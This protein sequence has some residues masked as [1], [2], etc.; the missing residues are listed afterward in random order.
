MIESLKNKKLHFIGIGGCGMSGLAVYV[1]HLGANVAGSDKRTSPYIDQIRKNDIQV[2][3]GHD[4]KNISDCDIIIYSS[5]IKDDNCELSFARQKGIPTFR[6]GVFLADIIKDKK[7]IAVSGSHGKTST[8]ALLSW[9][10]DYNGYCPN[11]LVGGI[12]KNVNSNVMCTESDY[13]IVEA[14]ESDGSITFFEPDILIILNIDDDHIEHYGTK[15]KML[16]AYRKIAANT[17]E[18]V[19]VPDKN[20]ADLFKDSLNGAQLIDFSIE[21]LGFSEK[22]SLNNVPDGIEIE[23]VYKSNAPYKFY[24]PVFGQFFITNFLS[25]FAVSDRLGVSVEKFQKYLSEFKGVKRRA[26]DWGVVNGIRIIE[27]YAHHPTEILALLESLRNCHKDR[28]ICVF[29]PHRYTRSKNIASSLADSMGN[30]DL[31]VLTDIYSADEQ[32]IEGI[33]GEFV[34]KQIIKKRNANIKYLPNF[35]QILK[36]LLMIVKKNDLIV[37][38]G[39]GDIGK[40]ANEF[41][42]ELIKLQVVSI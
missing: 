25:V 22:F 30:A 14:D 28:I 11:S 39:A 2:S 32:P 36:N 7:V 5:A 41:K 34:F 16:D 18:A 19:Y 42:N 33:S 21:N 27:D 24:I 38:M 17:K 40:L 1:K 15:D 31:L 8:S 26:E 35:D 4:V 20:M 29:Q 9:V 13:I 10:L 6:R 12:M 23:M 3:I 37:F